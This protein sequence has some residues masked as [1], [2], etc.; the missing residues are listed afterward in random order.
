MAKVSDW[1]AFIG[2]QLVAVCLDAGVQLESTGGF[3]VFSIK[4]KKR[5]GLIV[6]RNTGGRVSF[7]LPE[8]VDSF[9]LHTGKDVSWQYC[10][11][12]A[13]RGEPVDDTPVAL[14]ID[15]RIPESLET[16]IQRMIASEVQRRLPPAPQPRGNGVGDP[17]RDS[18][19]ELDSDVDGDEFLT[20]YEV[21]GSMSQ[22]EA[23]RMATEQGILKPPGSP[24]EPVVVGDKPK[25][26]PLDPATQATG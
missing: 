26:P 10:W 12:H 11:W 8:G 1:K 2:F 19:D 4:D 18:D 15:A 5:G 23:V 3:S 25:V 13:R 24:A 21:V 6:H 16:R 22:Q 7:R 20:P 17:F 14:P 9:E